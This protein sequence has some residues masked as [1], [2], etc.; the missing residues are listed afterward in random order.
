MMSASIS[1]Q[2]GVWERRGV[3]SRPLQLDARA[4]PP[5]RAKRAPLDSARCGRAPWPLQSMVRAPVRGPVVAVVTLVR[6]WAT[7]AE[8]TEAPTLILVR[9]Q[10]PR[11]TFQLMH[12][13]P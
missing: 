4:S 2:T 11:V 6:R 12:W 13:W 3:S 1:R 5:W 10:A 7:V 9:N 8:G